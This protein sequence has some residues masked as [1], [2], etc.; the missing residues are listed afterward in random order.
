[1]SKRLL[2]YRDLRKVKGID[3]TRQHITRLEKVGKFPRRVRCGDGAR[4]AWLEDEIDALIDQY[5]AERDRAA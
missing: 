3:Y 4:V 5:V 2:T 1:M